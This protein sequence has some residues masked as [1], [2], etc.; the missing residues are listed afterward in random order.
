MSNHWEILGHACR[1]GGVGVARRIVIHKVS[2][3]PFSRQRRFMC[4]REIGSSPLGAE[5]PPALPRCNT[6]I[7]VNEDTMVTERVGRRNKLRVN[8]FPVVLSVNETHRPS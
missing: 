3:S 4:I 6:I 5:D 1:E 8:A 7:A 2:K